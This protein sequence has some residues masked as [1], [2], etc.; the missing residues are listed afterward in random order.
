MTDDDLLQPSLDQQYDRLRFHKPWRP[1]S[2]AFATFFG[3]A[4][5]AA[6]L[7]SQNFR[8]LGMKGGVA[9]TLVG[10]L[11]LG[12]VLGMA[13]LLYRD[14]I[15]ER[16]LEREARIV[17]RVV[18]LAPALWLSSVQQKRFRVFESTGQPE[19][20]LLLPAIGAILVAL[21]LGV[22]LAFVAVHFFGVTLE[23]RS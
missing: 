13:Q 6:L 19:G 23:T 21:V 3:G 4:F 10:F 18:G 5:T 12:V 7:Y 16:D 14:A 15:A 2:L 11:I 9:P 8:R 22:L 17:F 20:K 1:W